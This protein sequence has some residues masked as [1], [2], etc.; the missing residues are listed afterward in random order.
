VTGSFLSYDNL[1][2]SFIHK[3]ELFARQF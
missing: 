2:Q 3:I 1:L